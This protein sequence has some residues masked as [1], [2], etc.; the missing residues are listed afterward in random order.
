MYDRNGLEL[1]PVQTSM[2]AYKFTAVNVAGRNYT[3]YAQATRNRGIYSMI[4]IA[5][6]DDARDAA[7][8]GQE[9]AKKF[10]ISQAYEMVLDKTFDAVASEF[11]TSIDMPVWQFPAEGLDWDDI[12]GGAGYEKNRVDNA[13]EALVEALKIASKPA[14]ALTAAK[15]L[16]DSVE[17]LYSD[18]MSYREAAKLVVNKC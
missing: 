12:V 11:V 18:G 7:F 8:V 15:K 5:K 9:F 16:I 3:A 17:K 1:T 13:R 6:F 4:T 14:P 2:N 10:T